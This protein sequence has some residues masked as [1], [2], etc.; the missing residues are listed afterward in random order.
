MPLKDGEKSVVDN[1]A[2]VPLKDEEKS[3]VLRDPYVFLDK[4][5]SV[6]YWETLEG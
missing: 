2:A 1:T 6:E 3:V 4:V 5:C